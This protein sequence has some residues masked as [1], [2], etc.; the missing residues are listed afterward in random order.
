MTAAAVFAALTLLAVA[1]G[2]PAAPAG[3][4]PH[5]CAADHHGRRVEVVEVG[6][7]PSAEDVDTL[8]HRD[9]Y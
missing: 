6:Q 4:C 5:L 3:C 7:L 9:A 2:F 8:L 1:A